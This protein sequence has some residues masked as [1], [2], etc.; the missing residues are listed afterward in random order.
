MADTAAH[1]VDHVLPAVPIRQW[2]LTLPFPLRYR[3]AFD[4]QLQSAIL[5]LFLGAVFRWLCMKA[6]EDGVIDT[7]PGAVTI[8]QRAGG[9]LNLNPPL[10]L[11]RARRCLRSS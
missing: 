9:S 5:P 11:P 1:L 7:R 4:H 6:K 10:P 2:V 3:V 8:S